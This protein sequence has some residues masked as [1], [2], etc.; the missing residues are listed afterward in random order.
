MIQTDT[1]TK[2]D[3]M[4]FCEEMIGVIKERLEYHG[5]ENFTEGV[6]VEVS[7]KPAY[8]EELGHDSLLF[9]YKPG[10]DT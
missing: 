8:Q 1:H 6:T 2:K 4:E 5:V 9:Y 10:E 7:V 3:F